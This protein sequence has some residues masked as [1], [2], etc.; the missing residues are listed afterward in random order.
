M[1]IMLPYV[2]GVVIAGLL[3]GITGAFLFY[4]NWSLGVVFAAMATGMGL[5]FPL[6]FKQLPPAQAVLVVILSLGAL[7]WLT[8]EQH[9]RFR[10]RKS[11]AE[12][13]LPVIVPV[14]EPPVQEAVEEATTG[15]AANERERQS[16]EE[17]GLILPDTASEEIVQSPV[18]KEPFQAVT[19]EIKDIPPADLEISAGKQVEDQKSTLAETCSPVVLPSDLSDAGDPAAAF[20]QALELDF[21][22]RRTGRHTRRKIVWLYYLER[23]GGGLPPKDRGCILEY[24]KDMDNQ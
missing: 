4:R 1:I 2:A 12:E 16:A 15:L 10:Q 8:V 23:W 3:A 21:L 13:A 11:P 7:A 14:N 6:L 17:T 19:K 20:L 18:A 22:L 9:P 24:L 5:V